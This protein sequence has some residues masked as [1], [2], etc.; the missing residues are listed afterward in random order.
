MAARTSAF[1]A[2]L[3]ARS[4]N[5]RYDGIAIAS[6]MPRMMMTTSSSMRVKPLSSP[7][8]RFRNFSRINSLLLPGRDEARRSRRPQLASNSK[9][10]YG[11]APVTMSAPG[12]A[13]FQ[14]ALPTVLWTQYVVDDAVLMKSLDGTIAESYAC[15]AVTVMPA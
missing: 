12:P 8:I 9:R 13:L 3:L 7:A 2:E 14:V 6:R 11:Q 1:A 15:R 10:A 4:R 5:D